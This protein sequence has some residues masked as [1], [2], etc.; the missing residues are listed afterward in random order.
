VVDAIDTAMH[1]FLF[2][3]QDA[4]DR[5]LGVEILV[6]GRNVAEESGML[7]GEQ[8]GEG[9]WIEKYSRYS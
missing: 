5:E 9:G 1:D 3:L 8:L 4:H 6:D 2:A 7:N